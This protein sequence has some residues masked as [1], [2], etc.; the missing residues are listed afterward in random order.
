[1]DGTIVRVC[2]FGAN[3]IIYIHCCGQL[4]G[5]VSVK[6]FTISS[7]MVVVVLVLVVVVLVVQLLLPLPLLSY[8]FTLCS[9]P[10]NNFC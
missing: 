9:N 5:V 1:M 7:A 10:H 6:R 2:S 8:C 4:L 3:I